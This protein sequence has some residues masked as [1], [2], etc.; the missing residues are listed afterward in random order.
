VGESIDP[1]EYDATELRELA[2]LRG[3][4]YLD[5]GFLW[6]ELP[7]SF[8]R[9]GASA[10]QDRPASWTG[11]LDERQKPYLQRLPETDDA[12]RIA[13]EWVRGLVER[14]G[15]QGALEALVYYESLGWLTEATRNEL[16][17]YLLAVEYRP[18]GSLE[19]LTRADH[20][21]SLARTARLARFA[22]PG[23]SDP[24]P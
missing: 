20:V 1:I 13:R 16:E 23:A 3:D 14:A 21:E 22:D 6:T 5:E 12:R 8:L 7:E 24:G 2:R 4:R 19:D 9:A 11:S 18:G 17:G 15:S 10:E